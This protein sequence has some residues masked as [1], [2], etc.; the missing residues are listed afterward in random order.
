MRFNFQEFV[1]QQRKWN[2]GERLLDFENLPS[3]LA[4]ANNLNNAAVL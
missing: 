3:L 2:G 4:N 1:Y